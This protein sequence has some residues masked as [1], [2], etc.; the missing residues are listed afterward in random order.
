M[1][2]FYVA[3]AL[4]GFQVILLGIVKTLQ[5]NKLWA[6]SL[7]S[8][9]IFGVGLALTLGYYMEMGLTGIWI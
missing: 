3:L 1:Y 6:A 2:I 5:I 8:Y 4:T 9:Y 7:V